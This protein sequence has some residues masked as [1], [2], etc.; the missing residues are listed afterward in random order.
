MFRRE[1]QRRSAADTLADELNFRL[2]SKFP[3]SAQ[4]RRVER[5]DDARVRER[6]GRHG[7]RDARVAEACNN[8]ARA[9]ELQLERPRPRSF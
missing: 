5:Y 1:G 9:V 4:R 6:R 2:W 7:R 8:R 3:D